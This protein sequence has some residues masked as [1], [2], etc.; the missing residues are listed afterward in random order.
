M[1]EPIGPPRVLQAAARATDGVRQRD[2]RGVLADHAAVQAL[3]HV[4]QLLGFTLE[5]LVD[6][7]AGHL[8]DQRRDVLLGH[9]FRDAALGAPLGDTLPVLGLDLQH[10]LLDACRFLEVFALGGRVEARLRFI[11]PLLE[12]T[13]FGRARLRLDDV[14]RGGLVDQVDRLVGQLALGQVARGE[15]DGALD[16]G[17]R[18]AQAVV[19]LVLRAQAV[20]DR[21]RLVHVGLVHE[22]GREAPLECRVGLDVAPVLLERGRTDDVQLATRQGGLHHRRGID[23]ALGAARPHHLVDLV[24]EEQHLTGRLTHLA[25]DRLQPLLELTAE[26]RAGDQLPHI[27]GEHALVA[28]ALGHLVVDDAA[29]EALDDGGLADAGLT[30]EH[31]VVLRAPVEDLHHARDLVLTTDGRVE[32]AVAGELREVG[33]VA[34][35]RLVLR[36]RGRR[37]DARAAAHLAEGVVDALLRDLELAQDPGGLALALVGDGDE[38]VLDADV[39]VL[40]ALGLGVRCLEHADDPRCRVDLDDLELRLGSAAEVA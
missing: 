17:L 27:E 25:H 22:H 5:H 18:D 33:R 29:R 3:L 24:D 19:L 32:L 4:E 21:N 2:D 11:Q 39:L 8:R 1:N 31:G 13:D 16:R 15:P 34:R 10:L 37:G 12:V 38:Q 7:D 23:G 30:D 14:L 36:L 28:Q 35:E 9:L 6:G 26:L 20:Q 40:Q